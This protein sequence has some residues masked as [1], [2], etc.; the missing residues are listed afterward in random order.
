MKRSEHVEQREFVQWWRRTYPDHWI[1]AIPNGGWRT[2]ATAL[3][4]KLEGVSPG[5]PDLFIPSLAFFIEMKA[6]GGTLS[7][8]QKTWIAHLESCQYT[9]MVAYGFEDAV[10]Q[11][12]ALAIAFALEG[13]ATATIN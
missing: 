5:V 1:F 4:L 9:V 13:A 7:D 3:K 2:P 6:V 10:R 11:F 8:A 12:A